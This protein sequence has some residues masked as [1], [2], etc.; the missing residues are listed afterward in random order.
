MNRI[1]FIYFSFNAFHRRVIRKTKININ[2]MSTQILVLRLISGFLSIFRIVFSFSSC[3]D[4]GTV[5]NLL[6]GIDNKD[7]VIP[8]IVAD[9]TILFEFVKP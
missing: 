8:H 4:F 9:A 6:K 2:N 7:T 1:S 3:R 5:C